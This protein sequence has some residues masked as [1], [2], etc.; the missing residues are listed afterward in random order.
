MPLFMDFHRIDNITIDD[1]VNAH[2]ADVAIQEKYGVRYHQFW[3]N[4]KAGTVFCLTEG[5]DAQTCEKVHQ[6]AHGNMACAI[7]EVE[8]GY[9]RLLMGDNGVVEHGL[10]KNQ[11][12]SVDAGYR[13]IVV[14]SIR[15][16][17]TAED[18]SD[19]NLLQV[20]LW[21][22]HA[23][24]KILQ[25]FG[26]REIKWDFVGCIIGVFNDGSN[27]VSFAC[28]VQKVLSAATDFPKVT[29]KIGISADQ[30]V[31]ENGEFFAR[32]IRL[33]HRLCTTAGDNQIIASSLVK[34]I[35]EAR[36]TTSSLR[37]L[38]LSEEQFVGAIHQ[39]AQEN[40]S[41]KEFTVDS[42]CREIGISR[43]Q[44]YRKMTAITGR[45]PNNFLRD[46]RMERALSLLRDRSGNIAQI[47]LEVGYN[48][49]SY[50]SKCFT[51]KFGCSPSNLNS[52]HH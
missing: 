16:I 52:A 24:V 26:G 45:A 20:P 13:N 47:A 36:K 48:N 22:N 7:T 10:V 32:A 30:P 39:L 43:P 46:I 5:P 1:V 51:Q 42:L 23:V 9:F 44:L 40:L 17:T 3:V 21:A 37:Y 6:M 8:P 38:E 50:F 25:Q 18:S 15:G 41:N 33:A 29:F 2:I 28:E 35:T 31:T 12:G 27:A 14:T 4:Q 34:K 19:L 11:D 49:P